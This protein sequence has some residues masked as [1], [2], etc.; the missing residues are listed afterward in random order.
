MKTDTQLQHEV[1]ESLQREPRVTVGEIGVA[2]RDGA[3]TLTGV[4]PT[5]AEKYT[6]E[7]VALRVP[8]VRAVAEE[9]QVELP[10]SRQH[11]DEAIAEAVARAL[12]AHVGVPAEVQ[13]TVEH[14]WATLQ[15]EVGEE[16]QREAALN[17]VRCLPGV[18]GIYNLIV[19]RSRSP[20]TASRLAAG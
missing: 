16:Y 8:G 20:L 2:V 3:V 1:V 14:G 6:A 7:Q 13:A 4:V 15:G 11:G 9:I 19:V 18:R 10:H 17:V 5:H 12:Q